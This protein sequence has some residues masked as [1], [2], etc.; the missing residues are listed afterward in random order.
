MARL[1]FDVEGTTERSVGVAML[2]ARH[3][4]FVAKAAAS[5][6]TDASAHGQVPALT[7]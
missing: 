7:R 5:G 3:I 4:E 1:A 6:A 2:N